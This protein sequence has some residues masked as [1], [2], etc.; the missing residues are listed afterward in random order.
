[1]WRA[2]GRDRKA[3][4]GSTLSSV[5]KNLPHPAPRQTSDPRFTRTA[6]TLARFPPSLSVSLAVQ[7]HV[8]DHVRLVRA[9]GVTVDVFEPLVR[10]LARPRQL[11]RN[12]AGPAA[13]LAVL[14][15]HAGEGLGERSVRERGRDDDAAHPP[16]QHGRDGV[17]ADDGLLQTLDGAPVAQHPA[18]RR[19]DLLGAV[20]LGSVPCAGGGH[21]VVNGARRA[22]LKR[23]ARA[24]FSVGPLQAVGR[25]REHKSRSNIS[26]RWQ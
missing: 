20:D 23:F 5:P 25:L 18:V 3:D 22:G 26:G 21:H 10:P 8:H 1:M 12:R 16:G 17:G 4:N 11:R 9:V 14:E 24:H 7:L 15:L 13:F 6:K 2:V 19:V